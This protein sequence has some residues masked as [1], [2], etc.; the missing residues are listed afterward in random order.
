MGKGDEETDRGR[1]VP[2]DAVA[3]ANAQTIL[4]SIPTSF[5]AIGVGRG[6]PMTSR[7][8][9]PALANSKLVL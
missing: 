9:N 5:G 8:S 3:T 2:S 6:T 7:F 1:S 4:G